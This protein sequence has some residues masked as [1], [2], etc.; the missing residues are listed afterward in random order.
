MDV[1]QK[2]NGNHH[3]DDNEDADDDDDDDDDDVVVVEK[4]GL[5]FCLYLQICQDV[6]RED[7]SKEIVGRVVTNVSTAKFTC[8]NL[9][10]KFT[11]SH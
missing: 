11:S 2:Q 7:C 1:A 4:G 10:M 8:A 3:D 5:C 6:T 9:R